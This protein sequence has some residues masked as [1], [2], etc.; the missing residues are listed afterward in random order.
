[1]SDYRGKTVCVLDHG[2]FV[3]WAALLA[4][5]FGTVLYYMPW[6]TSFPK[7]NQLLVGQGIPGV[8]RIK[9]FWSMLDDIDLFV[10]PGFYFG[11][12]QTYLEGIG[13]RVW[14]PRVADQLE[15]DRPGSKEFCREL[16]I[17]IGPYV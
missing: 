15:L 1:M 8:H 9:E 12:P 6:E 10:C 3:E 14:G 16:G 5:D 11:T 17:D 7:S 4:R 13:K 2:L